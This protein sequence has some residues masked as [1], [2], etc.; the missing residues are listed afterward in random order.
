MEGGGKWEERGNGRRGEGR[1]REGKGF[2]GP[3]S[4]CFLYAVY[5]DA[6]AWREDSRGPKTMHSFLGSRS[7]IWKGE[8]SIGKDICRS[9]DC[10][11]KGI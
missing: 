6:F 7:A 10:P 4:N 1:E 11:L 9:T 5:Q 8:G 2:A 3:L